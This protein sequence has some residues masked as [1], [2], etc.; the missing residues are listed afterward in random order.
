MTDAGRTVVITGASSGFGA[1]AARAFADRGDRVWGAMRDAGGR[2]AARMAELEA[3]S[4]RIA[5][6]EMDVASDASVA[7]GFAR[8]LAEGPVDVLINNAGIMYM[9]M[10]EAYSRSQAAEQR[11]AMTLKAMRTTH[12]ALPMMRRSVRSAILYSSS[13]TGRESAPFFGT[14]CAEKPPEEAYSQSL[15]YEVAPLHVNLA[16]VEPGPF[17]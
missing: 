2:N 14:N 4:P 16:P 11:D 12:T 10:T 6:A 5:I 1:A 8:I 9:C 3:Y 7:D 17:P 13:P 15:R